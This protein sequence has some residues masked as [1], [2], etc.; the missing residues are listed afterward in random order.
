[1][2]ENSNRKRAPGAG[3]GRQKKHCT[4]EGFG[5]G[6]GQ[7]CNY[8]KNF[9]P[10]DVRPQ[11]IVAAVFDGLDKIIERSKNTVALLSS[12]KDPNR[13][14]GTIPEKPLLTDEVSGASG[15]KSENTVKQVADRK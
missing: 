5:Q 12:K 11:S 2:I 6:R 14:L 10:A 13:R 7:N 8:K 9:S 15:D 3:R 1:M 4:N